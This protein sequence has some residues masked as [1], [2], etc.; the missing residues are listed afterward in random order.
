VQH[1]YVRGNAL[2]DMKT[3]EVMSGCLLSFVLVSC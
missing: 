2:V 3:M 1:P